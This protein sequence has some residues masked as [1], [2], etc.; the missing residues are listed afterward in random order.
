VT[1]LRSLTVVLAAAITGVLVL[2]ACGSTAGSEAALTVNGNQLS[3]ADFR[4]EL[5]ILIEH[6]QFAQIAFDAVP[7]ADNPSV[8]N[9][10][11]AG[12]V[13]RLRVFVSLI[14]AEFER[15]GLEVTDADL[16]RADETFGPELVALLDELPQ[17]YAD[18][19]RHWNAQL[20]VMRDQL[21][22]EAQE[23]GDDVTDDE[24]AQFYEDHQALF[25]DEQVCARHVL[26]DTEA[27]ADDV[28][29]ELEGGTDF[30]QLAMER[31]IDPSAQLNQGDLGCAGRGQ[32]VPEF[33][34]AVWNGPVGEVQGPVGTDF[35]F[36]VILVDS[37]GLPSFEE[38]EPDIRAFL[39][40]P[41]SRQ[42]QQLLNLL[43][44]RM[45]VAAEVTVNP[46]Y[47]EWDA[48]TQSVVPTA[49]ARVGGTGSGS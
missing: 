46:K 26:V 41:A 28:I 21:E 25:T 4:E 12:S 30:G 43:I 35:G 10:E 11:F 40:S 45:A 37:R 34:D 32:Y 16:A 17:D 14:D 29:T 23:R 5:D 48:T 3:D 15:R 44:Q 7:D 38:I 20:V 36:H 42:G 47:G 13:L 18:Q 6:P 39:E 33:E 8:V 27:E 49:T 2:G 24:V 9:Q 1:R 31:S 22:V 19:F